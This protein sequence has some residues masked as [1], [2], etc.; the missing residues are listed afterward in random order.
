MLTNY[1]SDSYKDLD[2]II[3]KEKNNYIKADPFP[4]IIFNNFFKTNIIEQLLKNFPSKLENNRDSMI[5][6]TNNENKITATPLQLKYDE[7]TFNFFNFLNSSYF[8]NFLQQITGIKEKLI[9]DPYF[10]GGGFCSV[11][12]G[13]FLKI[14]SDFNTHPKLKL[15]RRINVLI[16]LNKDWK[17]EYG[18]HL[19]LWNRDMTQCR[20]K[21]FPGFNDMVIFN[22]DDFSYHGHPTPLLCPEDVRRNSVA[23]YYYTNGRPKSEIDINNAEHSTLWKNRMNLNEIDVVKVE[24]KKVF[25]KFYVKKKIKSNLNKRD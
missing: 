9:S 14:H 24:Y 18:G 25:G 6:S 16:Y 22:T 12:N 2:S 1:L 7:Q 10:W 23:M 13:G 15:C 8:L 5:W 21:I 11:K 17:E 20:K 19:E 4:H 3:Q